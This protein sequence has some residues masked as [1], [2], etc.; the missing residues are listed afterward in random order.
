M[1]ISAVSMYPF[2]SAAIDT[3][4]SSNLT[5]ESPSP[6]EK[7]ERGKYLQ[8]QLKSYGL[9]STWHLKK[10]V[11]TILNESMQ[12]ATLRPLLQDREAHVLA[13]VQRVS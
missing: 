1:G 11:I 12:P 5:F 4:R 9:S 6:F 3:S 2:I 10:T 7:V 13:R 8:I